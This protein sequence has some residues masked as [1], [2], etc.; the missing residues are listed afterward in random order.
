MRTPEDES[1]LV[2]LIGQVRDRIGALVDLPTTPDN[3]R[4][5]MLLFEQLARLEQMEREPEWARALSATTR[6]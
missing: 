5:L 1:N 3:L 2:L 6:H 4:D